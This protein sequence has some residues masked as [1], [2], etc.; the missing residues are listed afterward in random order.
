MK[1]KYKLSFN[2]V[3]FS[4]LSLSFF[5]GPDKLIEACSDAKAIKE[6]KEDDKYVM[7][8]PVE[9]RDPW[10]KMNL[11]DRANIMS[12]D[13]EKKIEDGSSTWKRHYIECSHEQENSPKSFK[14]KWE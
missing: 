4:A 2:V 9:S 13:L 3:L 11:D 6:L 12:W 5:W 7:T 10:L 1:N 14:K 8:L